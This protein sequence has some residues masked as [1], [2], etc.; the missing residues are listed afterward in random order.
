MYGAEDALAVSGEWGHGPGGGAAARF[1]RNGSSY[2]ECKVTGGNFANQYGIGFSLKFVSSEFC[3][4]DGRRSIA[5][6][7]TS[8]LLPLV[9]GSGGGGGR[10]K[11][12]INGPGGGGGGGA[13][14]LAASGGVNITG[15][16]TADGGGAGWARRN[17]FYESGGGSGGAIRII[18]TTVSGTGNMYAR[19]GGSITSAYAA[20]GRIRIETERMRFSG[21]S[22]PQY[23]LGTP[24]GLYLEDR[25]SVRIVSVGTQSVPANP[26]GSSD[27]TF[28]EAVT[29]NTSISL[30][31]SNVPVGTVVT[32]NVVPAAGAIIK[33][34]S[35]PLS[36]TLA[37]STAS[38][39]VALPAGPSRLQAVAS[40]EVSATDSTAQSLYT[41]YTG[42]EL[43]AHVS[44]GVGSEPGMT[45]TTASGREVLVP[46]PR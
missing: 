15:L 19:G 21:R 42:G 5:A 35:T 29:G 7:G 26:S 43:V 46:L 12:G 40:F 1:E 3:I 25:P 2:R 45:L 34:S 13:L 31:A 41:P 20:D 18:A 38:A 17:F 22:L 23:V 8:T 6:Y 28:A 39:T 30:G 33:A 32:V 24:G 14:L 37:S 44:L 36:G 11:E 10:A 27:V 9:G 4:V 16:I